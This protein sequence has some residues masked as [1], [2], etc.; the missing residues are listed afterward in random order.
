MIYECAASLLRQRAFKKH[1]SNDMST[2]DLYTE[3]L[4]D[5]LF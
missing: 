2:C 4:W 1:S 5:L 3:K